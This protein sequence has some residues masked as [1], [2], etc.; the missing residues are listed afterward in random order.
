MKTTVSIRTAWNTVGNSRIGN[1]GAFEAADSPDEAALLKLSA[2][3]H[4]FRC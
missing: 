1:G 2:K 4:L 3:T